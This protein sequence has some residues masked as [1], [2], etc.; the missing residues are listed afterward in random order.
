[1]RHRKQPLIAILETS[2]ISVI[3]I[4]FHF[5]GFTQN[6]PVYRADTFN[7]I[8]DWITQVDT[9]RV[10]EHVQHLQDYM[11]R[12][13]FTTNA[14]EAQNWIKDQYT[15][16]GLS[17]ELQDFPLY[18]NNPSDNVLATMTGQVLPEEYIIL[19]GHYDSR[20]NGYDAPGADDNASGTSGVLEVAQILSQY[21]FQRSVIFCAFSAEEYGLSGSEAFVSRC[22]DQNLNILG[23]INMDMIG[24]L[25]PG[26]TLHSDM[27]A[28]TSAQ[29]LVDFYTAVTAIYLPTFP[30]GEGQLSGGDSDHTSFNNHGYQGIFPFEDAENYSPYI[31]TVNDLVG[32]SFNSPLL[33]SK[34]IQAGLASVAT[35]AIPYNPVGSG[36]KTADHQKIKIYPNPAHGTVNIT[37]NSTEPTYF[38][39]IS[40]QG[41][42]LV[43]QQFKD[44]TSIDVTGITPGTYLLKAFNKDFAEHK[45]LI[46]K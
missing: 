12:D 6:Q 39:L 32:I 29:A 4:F 15:S 34:L 24:Y 10:I 33:A 41:S 16:L 37:L 23:Y 40:L 44:Y 26:N 8:Y 13:C 17:V 25:K 22:V 42:S 19:G 5:S 18:N 46:I 11:T 27:I 3:T 36:E 28:P 30:I 9:N 35:L 14:V 1:M 20:A 43:K 45:K 38:E 7:V 21:K 31:H 2:F